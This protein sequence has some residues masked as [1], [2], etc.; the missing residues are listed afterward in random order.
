MV[1]KL[2][3]SL[4]RFTPYFLIKTLGAVGGKDLDPPTIGQGGHGV[5][6]VLAKK[7]NHYLRTLQIN[8]ATPDCNSIS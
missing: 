4:L 3:V 5:Y 1:P 7:F 2:A 6:S 8:Q